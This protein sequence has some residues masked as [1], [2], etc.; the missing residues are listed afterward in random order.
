MPASIGDNSL[1]QLQITAF[2]TPLVNGDLKNNTTLKVYDL[3]GR[4]VAQTA[5]SNNNRQLTVNNS[6]GIYLVNLGNAQGSK[7]QKVIFK[8]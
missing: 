7:T 3:Q 4:K 8:T 1:E 5:L 6:A 2:K